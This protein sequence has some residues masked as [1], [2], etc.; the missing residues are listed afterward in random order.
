MCNFFSL[1]DL[2]MFCPILL[3]IHY[4]S[5]N[6]TVIRHDYNLKPSLSE[7]VIAICP[8]LFLSAEYLQSIKCFWYRK[9]FYVDCCCRLLSLRIH[10]VYIHYQR[11][12]ISGKMYT[13]LVFLQFFSVFAIIAFQLL[14]FQL[15]YHF[16]KS[17]NF[18]ILR[19]KRN[20]THLVQTQDH[21]FVFLQARF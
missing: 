20:N 7:F 5:Q 2:Q 1:C 8:N 21:I 11:N 18:L 4:T 3:M 9:C 12:K 19:C 10:F 14:F 17:A 6:P 13:F 15:S 16:R